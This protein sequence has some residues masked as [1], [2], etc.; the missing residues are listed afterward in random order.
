MKI[1]HRCRQREGNILV[2]TALMMFGMFVLL[3]LSVDVGYML[4]AHTQLQRSAD[5]AAIAGAWELVDQYALLG[6]G[7][8]TYA[9][10]SVRYT[11]AGYAAMNSVLADDPALAQEDVVVGYLAN[12]FDP[13]AQIDVNDGRL[14]AVQVRVRRTGDINGEIPLF[15]ARVMGI[16][17]ASSQA[18]ATA[19]L[20]SNFNGFSTPTSGGNLNILPFALDLQTWEALVAG[21]GTDDWAWD[22]ASET[23][24]GGSDGILEVNLFPQG[25]GSPG[26]RGTVDIGSNNNST[27]DIARQIVEG[28]SAEDLEYHGGKLEF[29]EN[30]ELELNA[31]T[32]ISAGMKDELE[33][34]KGQPRIIPVFSQIVGNGNNAQY[35][36]VK[37]VGIRI[38]EV[39]LTGNMNSK[40]VII[41]PAI[42]LTYGGIPATGTQTSSF[43]YS[44]VWLVR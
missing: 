8:N 39:K 21:V 33:S 42:T 13:S 43:V 44:P 22:T 12:P 36:I 31:D 17:Q 27:A 11:A 6:Y 3:A 9:A 28:I 38:M 26:N 40:R 41:Q 1:T 16:D 24:S 29:D 14:N 4:V 37:F 5:S 23:A 20:L 18:Q 10:E 15:F 2:L 30:G 34:I 19:A 7:D 25:T 35:T 32:G